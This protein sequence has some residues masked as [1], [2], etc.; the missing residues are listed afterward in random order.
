MSTNHHSAH[1]Y[2]VF[3]VGELRCGLPI[4]RIQEIDRNLPIT[5]VHT[6]PPWVRGVIN[7]RGRIVTII[8]LAERFGT[9]R[10]RVA[11][12]CK[13]VV[14]QADDELIGLLVDEVDD[15]VTPGP[16]GVLP[17]PPHLPQRVGQY[18]SGVLALEDT[19]VILLD[20]DTILD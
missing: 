12:D 14:A 17:S 5:R 4:Q 18:A 10:E 19:L 3:R 8:D 7:L 20:A 6:A 9:E 1:E 2:V 15:I 16:T 11:A 13:T